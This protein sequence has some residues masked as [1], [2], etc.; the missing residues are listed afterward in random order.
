MVEFLKQKNAI[1]DFTDEG[2]KWLNYLNKKPI[3]R[4]A[5]VSRTYNEKDLNNLFDNIDEIEL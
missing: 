1:I 5:F 3:N 2:S 4:N